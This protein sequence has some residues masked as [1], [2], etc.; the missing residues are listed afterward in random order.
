[1]LPGQRYWP[2]TGKIRRAFVVTRVEARAGRAHVQRVDGARERLTIKLERL[3]A[4]TP[5]HDGRFYRLMGYASDERRYATWA[6][7]IGISLDDDRAT[8]VAPEWHPGRAIE[9]PARHL[10][11]TAAEG[12]WVGCTAILAAQHPAGV[13]VAFT[14]VQDP[15]PNTIRP[16]FDDVATVAAPV[17]PAATRDV[18][19]DINLKT[20]PPTHSRGLTWFAVTERIPD[21]VVLEPDTTAVWLAEPSGEV[22]TRAELRDLH[23]TAG[24]TL[25]AIDADPEQLHGAALP[26]PSPSSAHRPGHLRTPWWQPAAPLAPDL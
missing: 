6:H 4:E 11:P 8:L 23:R 25:L 7:L 14:A 13:Q 2:L 3:L 15:P 24:A 22:R 9:I 21:Q 10:P 18:V 16:V 26:P 5:A 17:P 12:C 1:M 19:L 20:L